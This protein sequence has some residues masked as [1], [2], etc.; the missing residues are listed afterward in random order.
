MGNIIPLVKRKIDLGMG[1]VMIDAVI[2]AYMRY[3]PGVALI[4][5]NE[6]KTGRLVKSIRKLGS[7]KRKVNY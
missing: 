7:K 5:I 1:V 4:I 6:G 2:F 3:W